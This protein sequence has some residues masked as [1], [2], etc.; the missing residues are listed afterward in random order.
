MKKFVLIFF[1][2]FGFILAISSCKTT[3]RCDAYKSHQSH[4][5]Y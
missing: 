4:S 3:E 5:K 2:V 1:I